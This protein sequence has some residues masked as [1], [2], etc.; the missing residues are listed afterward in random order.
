MGER[1]SG[2]EFTAAD[3]VQQPR[4]VALAVLLGERNVRCGATWLAVSAYRSEVGDAVKI[5]IL[6]SGHQVIR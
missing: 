3:V 5:V 2:I 4:D 1:Q 6:Q